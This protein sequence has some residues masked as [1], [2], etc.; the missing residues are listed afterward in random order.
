MGAVAIIACEE[1]RASKQGDVLRQELPSRKVGVVLG[2][3]NGCQRSPTKPSKRW[4]IAGALWMSTAAARP[5]ARAVAGA[6]R[7]AWGSAASHTCMSHVRFKR[8]GAWWC[9]AHSHHMLALR[10]ATYNGTMH[11]V[12]VRY[13][14]RLWETSA[15]LT[16]PVP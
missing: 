8:C 11:Q 6:L 12:W 5:L 3:G 7:W 10:C 14:Q 4:L 9:E 13:Q 16:V 2:A 15:C 1:F